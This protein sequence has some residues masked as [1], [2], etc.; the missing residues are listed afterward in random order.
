MRRKLPKLPLIL[1]ILALF[2]FSN[3]QKIPH[4]FKE[5]AEK[6]SS[7]NWLERKIALE[8][9]KSEG[10]AAYYA[11]SE[12]L[13]R[14]NLFAKLE[15][16]E[17]FSNFAQ[18]KKLRG[19]AFSKLIDLFRDNNPLIRSRAARALG[20]FTGLEP[21]A[22]KVSLSILLSSLRSET[23]P[24]VILNLIYSLSKLDG[25]NKT[26]LSAL[27]KFLNSSNPKIAGRT[28]HSIICGTAQSTEL[29]DKQK[30][31]LQKKSLKA[32][33]KHLKNS[34]SWDKVWLSYLITEKCPALS[35]E[36]RKYLTDYLLSELVPLKKEIS[37]LQ[38]QLLEI[39]EREGHRELIFNAGRALSLFGAIAMRKVFSKL[40]ENREPSTRKKLLLSLLSFRGEN[41]RAEVL[42]WLE[43]TKNKLGK[44]FS[45]VIKFVELSCGRTAPS[46]KD[47]SR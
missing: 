47:E 28:A 14:A 35:T 26:V 3:C 9:L 36:Q 39:I 40:E 16:I 18:D 38:N 32:I 23:A 24:S 44:N 4:S 6:L 34:K 45:D 41:E 8:E 27:E 46:S 17:F 2:L 10:K 7:P 20:N 13:P 31:Q 29:D 21:E 37:A 1:S 5:Q 22:K 11:V 12:Y 42:L 30:F 33:I 25:H 19:E 43:R 15:S